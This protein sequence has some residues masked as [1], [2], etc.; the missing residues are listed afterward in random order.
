MKS[1]SDTLKEAVEQLKEAGVDPD[2][3][4]GAVALSYLL[5]TSSPATTTPGPQLS[6]QTAEEPE[7]STAADDPA[8]RVARRVEVDAAALRDRVEFDEDGAR[9]QVRAAQLP[10]GRA[11]RQRVLAL[12]KLTLDRLGFGIEE[13]PVQKLSAICQDYSAYDHNFPTNLAKR[14]DLISRRGSRG[15]F[16]Y[17]ITTPGLERGQ[18]LLRALVE[19]EDRL[20]V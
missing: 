16:R 15:G 6:T 12:L 1:R 2:S 4:S 3:A 18:E 8:E 17:R 7:G 10:Q 9:P 13:V 11:E 5:G 14:D 20:Q 19:G